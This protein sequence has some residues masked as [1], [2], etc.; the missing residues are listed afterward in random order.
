[1]STNVNTM[2]KLFLSMKLTLLERKCS[3]V[4]LE[5]IPSEAQIITIHHECPCKIGK[6]HPRGSV[7][8]PGTRLGKIPIPRMRFPILHGLAHDGLFLS[9]F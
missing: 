5:M 7:F 2:R 1:M 4:R 8:L 6:S 3:S 9:H